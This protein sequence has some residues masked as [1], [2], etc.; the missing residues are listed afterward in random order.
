MKTVRSSNGR[1]F[2]RVAALGDEANSF[3]RGEW[4]ALK[5][6]ERRVVS[7]SVYTNTGRVS[8]VCGAVCRGVIYARHGAARGVAR[9]ACPNSFWTAAW[10][11]FALDEPNAFV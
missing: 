4:A 1:R 6:A 9:D 7:D 3:I 11:P 2:R 10:R 5:T 8:N